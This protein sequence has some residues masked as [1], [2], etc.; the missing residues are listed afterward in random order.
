[1]LVLKGPP[2]WR[3]FDFGNPQDITADLEQAPDEYYVLPHAYGWAILAGPHKYCSR[4]SEG[5][6]LVLLQHAE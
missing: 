3:I 2:D 5:E 4:G 6:S 1:M